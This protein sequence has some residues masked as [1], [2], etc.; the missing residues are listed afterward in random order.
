M[1]SAASGQV[2]L[3]GAAP[4]QAEITGR[5]LTTFGEGVPNARVTLTDTSGQTRAKTAVTNGFGY[6]RFGGLEVGHTYTI[7]VDSRGRT[8]TPLTVSVYD[9]LLNID[10]LAQQ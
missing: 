4:N 1:T 7:N 9:Q 2:E 5:V 6:Y 3:S 8:F 10:M